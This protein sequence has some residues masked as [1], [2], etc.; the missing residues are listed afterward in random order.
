MA[1]RLTGWTETDA[2]GRS[3]GDV[4]RLE[5]LLANESDSHD[6][7]A[8]PS[9]EYLLVRQDGSSCPVE[10]THAVIHDEDGDVGGM[11]R[12]FRDISLR[13]VVEA[14][15]QALLQRQQEAR[16]A[17]DAANRSKDEF[18][19]LLSHELRTPMTAITGWVHLLKTGQLDDARKQTALGAVE[20]AARAQAA[21]VNDLLDISNI[22]RGSL[23]LEIRR[24]D[25]FEILREAVEIVHPA[26]ET[27]NLHL[28]LS[29]PDDV[30]LIDGDKDRLRQVFWN[31]LSNSA[32]F[33]PIDGTI[34]VI[35]RTDGQMVHV[36]VRDTGC[37]IAPEFLPFVFERFRQAN[38]AATSLHRGL[39][40]GLAIVREVVERHG[41]SVEA[42]SDGV[43]RGA[44]FIVR[45]PALVRRRDSDEVVRS[46]RA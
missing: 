31:L 2:R 22:I 30:F 33:T 11:I 41:G 6:I 36:E 34:D 40:L 10:Q 7:E 44:T 35:A 18:L 42:A 23:R 5:P 32:K 19:A 3:I 45:L 21:V 28:H 27:K 26:V 37:G 1:E 12:T 13:K 14:E 39:G 9:R 29:I 15:R 43:G 17:A 20:R 16:A 46:A 24:T 4:L 8:R 38:A 25:V